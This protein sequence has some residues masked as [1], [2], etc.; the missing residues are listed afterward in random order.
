MPEK[1]PTTTHALD[2]KRGSGRFP[3]VAADQNQKTWKPGGAQS[4][5]QPESCLDFLLQCVDPEA[6]CLSLSPAKGSRSL[7]TLGPWDL[8]W[9]LRLWPKAQ[10]LLRTVWAAHSPSPACCIELTRNTLLGKRVGHTLAHS[11]QA[12]R[13][14]QSFKFS[15]FFSNIYFY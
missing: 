15:L 5:S 2:R 4:S 8:L 10:L 6:I 7:S 14:S 13:L 9:M 1:I 11:V 12:S 3:D